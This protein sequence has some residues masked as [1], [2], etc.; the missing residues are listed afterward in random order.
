MEA[1]MDVGGLCNYV[2]VDGSRWMLQWKWI[3][4]SMEWVETRVSGTF[5]SIKVDARRGNVRSK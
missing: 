2:E 5:A 4:Y 3:S 1:S